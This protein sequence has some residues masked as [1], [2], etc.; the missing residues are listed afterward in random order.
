M[1]LYKLFAAFLLLYSCSVSSVLATSE[2][3]LEHEEDNHGFFDHED[4][5]TICSF[6]IQF[7]GHYKSRD[8]EGLS[9]VLSHYDIVVVQELVA[10]PVHGVF[11]NGEVYEAD[12]ES[13]AFVD[14]MVDE[15]FLYWLSSE[16]TGPT[17]N[18]SNTTASEWF[19]TFY[20][21]DKVQPDSSRYYGFIDNNLVANNV[22]QRVPF[23]FPFKTSDK[24][25][26]S[27]VSVHLI[28]G[29]GKEARTQ[30]SKELETLFSW[31][32]SIKEDNRDFFVLGDFN[33]YGQEEF[34]QFK[35]DSIFSLND[36]C[37]NTVSKAYEDEIRGK[38]YDHVFYYPES[39]EDILMNTFK[40]I[41]LWGILRKLYPDDT[42]LQFFDY[43]NFKQ[44]Y[45]DHLPIE[46]KIITGR[47]TD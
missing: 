47:D 21:A 9:K 6:N 34:E 29:E 25:S 37:S 31:P 17:K 28:P 39:N 40:V 45:S 24:T 16:D 32:N 8:N 11:P 5:L 3:A 27:L 2:S 13:S 12:P 36:A 46:F 20:K 19:I 33:I 4:T 7:L 44:R 38:P 18:H 23:V 35:K 1:R 43:Q 15:G 30:R 42:K 41:D 14:E 10:P 22:Y 26:F